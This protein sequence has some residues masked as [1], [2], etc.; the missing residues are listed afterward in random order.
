MELE[1]VL[2]KIRDILLT[3]MKDD[4]EIRAFDDNRTVIRDV[5]FEYIEEVREVE[6]ERG[7][8]MVYAE[9]NTR[10]GL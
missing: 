8:D 2:D 3:T 1:K 10:G 7:A 5:I 9:M 6:R 4:R